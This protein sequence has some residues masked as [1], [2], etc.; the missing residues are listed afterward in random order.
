MHNL[1][2]LFILTFGQIVNHPKSTAIPAKTVVKANSV[3]NPIDPPQ[4][5]TPF[6]GVP[7]T[8]DIV[9]Y[10]V[11]FRTFTPA[12]FKGVQARL[13]AIRNLGVNV[14]WLM[15]T[16][17]VGHLKGFGS[18]YSV[19]DYYG[20]NPDLGTLDD[21]RML[22]AE[23][24]QR[25]MAVI[26]DWVANH[27]AWE[28]GWTAVHKDW[29]LQD[30]AGNIVHPP[31]TNYTDVAALNYQNKAM[32]QAMISA[33]K[34]WIYTANIDGYRCDFADNVPANFW[35]QALDTL[36]TIKT[37]QLIYLAEGTTGAETKAGF[38]LS[39]GFDYYG[40]LKG[41]FAGTKSTDDLF[42]SNQNEIA[43]ISSRAL[44]LHYTTNHDNAASDGSTL[45]IFHNQ[46]G[47][48]AAFVLATYMGGV[49][50]IYS[51]QEVG[52]VNGSVDYNTNQDIA[53]AYKNIISF[54]KANE[55]IKTGKLTT[56]NHP[57]VVAFEKRAGNDDV[58]VL[59]NV[60]NNAV[61]Y[62]VPPVLQNT[63]WEDGLTHSGVTL[64][65]Q[66]TLQPYQYLVLKKG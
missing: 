34:Y 58:L 29:Y 30:A 2:I 31:K 33:M 15:P 59:V 66:L 49:P 53:A 4:Y 60:R 8:K 32:R 51:S 24:H 3:I 65:R 39:Y 26:M 37:H 12:T 47:A 23:A 6:K 13:D 14:I 41:V 21:L 18:P 22:V 28:N 36:N 27:T 16:Y 19:Q 17:P 5:G 11:N 56:Y 45:T 46:Q 20:V 40:T 42:T 48:L 9:M 10:E 57:D 7:A 52:Y 50:L 64:T 62:T 43:T 1:I 61:S 54:R 63:Q 38:Q 44:K 55:A 25:G 35:K